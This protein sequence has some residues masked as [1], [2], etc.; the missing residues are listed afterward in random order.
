MKR[1]RFGEPAE[2]GGLMVRYALGLLPDRSLERRI[3]QIWNELG[4]I[5]IS[6]NLLDD[7]GRPHM[8]LA[9][10]EGLGGDFERRFS[11]F[12]GA[13]AP[14][15]VSLQAA[16]T[17]G[18][19]N[20]VVFLAPAASRRFMRVHSSLYASLAES[21]ENRSKLYEP[22][23]WVPHCTVAMGLAPDEICRA[24]GVCAGKG[25]PMEGNLERAAVMEFG[26]SG[27]LACREFDLAAGQ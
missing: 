2:N 15:E 1:E 10:C 16:G 7:G 18:L 8:S 24:I 4:E 3:R 27:V 21:M 9:V 12:A 23:A 25:F 6:S 26:E 5:G 22:G 13:I 14:V 17:F 19:E 11:S 20:G